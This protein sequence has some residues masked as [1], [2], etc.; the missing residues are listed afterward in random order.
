MEN[1]SFDS[2]QRTANRFTINGISTGNDAKLEL[3]LYYYPGY[4]AKADNGSEL[5]IERGNNNRLRILFDNG[6]SGNIYVR[7]TEPVLWRVCE[8]ISLISMIFVLVMEI[9]RRKTYSCGKIM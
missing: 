1:V 3:P 4:T 6:F 9:R 8:V 7:Y 5:K 2:V